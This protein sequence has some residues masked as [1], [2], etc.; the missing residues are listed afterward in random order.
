MNLTYIL[1]L[2]VALAM[3]CFT[4]SIVGGAVTRRVVWRP[5]LTMALLFG[6]FQGGM[7]LLGFWGTSL[8]SRYLEPV[9]HW[10]AFALLTY[11]GARMISEDLRKKE[12]KTFDSLDY[13]VILLLA[14]ATSIDALAVGVSFACLL[15]GVFSAACFPALLIGVVSSGF[16]GAGLAIGIAVGRKL[17]LPV[18]AL[19]GCI[20]IAIGARILIE[21]LT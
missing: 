15:D 5:M 2:A 1:L 7:L 4:V 21:H 12:E 14:V 18:E 13:K 17:H 16:T 11:L 20:L 6:L 8:F 19:G 3:D 10:I 9:D